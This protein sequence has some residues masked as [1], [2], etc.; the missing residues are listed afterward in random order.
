MMPV[1]N[2]SAGIVRSPPGPDDHDARIEG[3]EHGRQIRRRIGVRDVA[4]DRAAIA[5]RRI[6]DHRRGVGQR[7]RGRAQFGGGGQLGMRRQRAD[8]Q[9]VALPR[10]AAQLG[11]RPMSI[12]AGGAASRS[13]SS[14]IE[15]VAAGQQLR[16]RM[17]GEQRMR[18]GDGARAVIVEVCGAYMYY[19]PPS[20]LLHGAP[21]PLGR[22]GIRID[23]TPNGSSA[24]MTALYTVH[25]DAIVPASPMPFT[26]SGWC[27][28]GVTVDSTSMSGS[29]SAR[30]M[31]VVGQRAGQQLAVVVVDA[32]PPTAPGRCPG[33][34]RRAP[35]LRR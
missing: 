15:A 26:P 4:A 6:A 9:R 16:A 3:D 23:S 18:V 25:V 29:T 14:G 34:R 12:T 30:G 10:D 5:H 27:G 7:R 20:R 1:K 31:R 11:T 19:A 28:D 17:R 33:R 21:Y 13:F 8:P 35:A 2:S 22:H 24:S 32:P